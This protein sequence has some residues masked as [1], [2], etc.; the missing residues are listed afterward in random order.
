MSNINKKMMLCAAV[1]GEI[2]DYKAMMQT[3]LITLK[4]PHTENRMA[5]STIVN[6]KKLA[7]E[8]ESMGYVGRCERCGK[9]YY[10]GQ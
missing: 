1:G 8:S 4:C 6:L 2:E 5:T 3:N 9:I 10:K 7:F